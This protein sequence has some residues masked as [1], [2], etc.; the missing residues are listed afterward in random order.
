MSRHKTQTARNVVFKVTN[1]RVSI[2]IC[3][4]LGVCYIRQH[5]FSHNELCMKLSFESRKKNGYAPRTPPGQV[6]GFASGLRSINL[7]PNIA[8]P[9]NKSGH[10]G[11]IAPCLLQTCSH[12]PKQKRTCVRTPRS[13]PP[14]KKRKLPRSITPPSRSLSLPNRLRS[15][16]PRQRRALKDW[17]THP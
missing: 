16:R 10:G 2:V 7:F 3:L 12:V 11:P 15:V 13:Y 9:S 8:R 14:N 5:D 4:M 17:Q 1:F 6:P